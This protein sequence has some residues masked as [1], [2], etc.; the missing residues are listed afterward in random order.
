MEKKLTTYEKTLNCFKN[1]N[2]IV[3]IL[4]FTLV[5]VWLKNII[6]AGKSIKDAFFP[7]PI[8]KD[9]IIIEKEKVLDK[10]SNKLNAPPKAIT[11][12]KPEGKTI[13]TYISRIED[14]TGRGIADVKIYCPNCIKKET[15]TDFNGNFLLNSK[16]SPS[17]VFWKSTLSLSK[18]GKKSTIVVDWRENQPEPIRF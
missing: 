3:L 1:N 14:I 12:L 13:K 16:F 6:E 4:I 9:T 11:K 7:S 18:E 5:I 17:E 10:P 8:V 2:F 15:K